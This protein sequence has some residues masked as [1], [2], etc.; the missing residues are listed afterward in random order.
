MSFDIKA[1]DGS[2]YSDGQSRCEFYANEYRENAPLMTDLWTLDQYKSQWKIALTSL[3]SAQV[4]K[5]MLVTDMRP[6]KISHGLMYYAMYADNNNII[7]REIMHYE[8]MGKS[9][10]DPEMTFNSKLIENFI[11]DRNLEEELKQNTE[12]GFPYTADEW[13]INFEDIKHLTI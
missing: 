9:R 5:C 10:I 12:D 7:I 13:V 8:G 6:R 3:Y 2:A 4:L 1:V 11:S